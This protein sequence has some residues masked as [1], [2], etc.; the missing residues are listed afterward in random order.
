MTLSKKA[1][2]FI[3]SFIISELYIY[4]TYLLMD[5]LFRDFQDLSDILKYSGVILCLIFVQQMTEKC[6]QLT[7]LPF[8]S[9]YTSIR[10][11]FYAVIFC[12]FLLL[13]T[14][15]FVLGILVFCIVQVVYFVYLRGHQTLPAYVFAVLAFGLGTVA[16]LYLMGYSWD[17][18][19]SLSAVYF[20][21]L[22]G[23][24]LLALHDA[25]VRPTLK[26]RVFALG[27]ALFAL[28]DLNVG[29]MNASMCIDMPLSFS[30]AF[31]GLSTFSMWFFYLPALVLIALTPIIELSEAEMPSA[32]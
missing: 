22:V 25:I 10:A 12:D 29:L 9:T 11:A 28:C 21:M 14:T 6:P 19:L 30:T 3:K 26:N 15:Q 27:L 1:D 2:F 23:N 7:Q 4:I 31:R 32:S 16:V 8:R 20:I 24:L 18:L 17:L 5:L 13:F